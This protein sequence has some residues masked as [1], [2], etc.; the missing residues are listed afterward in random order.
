MGC[1]RRSGILAYDH[2]RKAGNP[3]DVIKHV[4]LIAALLSSDK[5]EH[6]FRFVD[7]FAGYA[8][9]PIVDGNEWCEGIGRITTCSENSANLAVQLYLDWYLSRPSL[10]GGMYPG[11]SLV[12]NDVLTYLGTGIELT[13][14]DISEKPIRNL[15]RVYGTDKHSIHHRAGSLDDPEIALADFMFIDPPGIRSLRESTYPKLSDL[16]E[17]AELPEMCQTLFWL[18]LT[19]SKTENSAAIQSLLQCGFDISRAVW[20]NQSRMIGCF[21]AYKLSVAGKNQLRSAVEE[22]FEIARLGVLESSMVDHLDA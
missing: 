2:N 21:L 22:A 17:L 10:V 11:S 15:K 13:L 6:A 8:Y 12:A 3:G 19:D 18:P 1:W 14:Y 7:L 20:A 9:N 4:G 5:T 16:I